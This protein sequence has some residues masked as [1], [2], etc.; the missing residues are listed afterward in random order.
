MYDFG[1]EFE[2]RVRPVTDATFAAWGI[3]TSF[4]AGWGF[5]DRRRVGFTTRRQASDNSAIIAPLSG[6]SINLGPNSADSYHVF[7]AVGVP[8]STTY[9]IF[10]D[11]ILKQTTTIANVGNSASDDV[12]FVESG[13]STGVGRSGNWNMLGLKVLAPDT[14]SLEV[15]KINGQVK[16]INNS[17]SAVS[18]NGY[19]IGSESGQ[20]KTNTWSSLEA[21]GLDGNGVPND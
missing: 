10:V 16:L 6:T 15:N 20:L 11:D 13:S 1:W 18:F 2:A 14:L 17:D 4:D 19:F 8:Q 7:R 21:S 12:F 9:S 5:T 3:G